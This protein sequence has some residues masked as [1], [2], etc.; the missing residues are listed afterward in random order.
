MQL[1]R[2]IN[3]KLSFQLFSCFPRKQKEEE[4]EESFHRIFPENVR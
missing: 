1:E 2:V 4:E 3:K